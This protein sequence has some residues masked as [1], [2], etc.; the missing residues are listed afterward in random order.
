VREALSAI[1]YREFPLALLKYSF[2][3]DTTL[4]ISFTVEIS[5]VSDKSAFSPKAIKS[6]KGREII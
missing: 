2:Q 1:N 4:V 5:F 3:F 6:A